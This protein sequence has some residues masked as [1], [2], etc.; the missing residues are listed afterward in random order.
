MTLPVRLTR[1]ANEDLGHASTR[2]EGRR[3]GLG[4]VFL[5]A[6]D[7]TIDSIA[8]WPRAGTSIKGVRA[9]LHA[10]RMGACGAD[11]GIRTRDPHLGKAIT[12]VSSCVVR[13]RLTRS[14]QVTGPAGTAS[15]HPVSRR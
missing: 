1:E 8:P 5:A 13:S 2:Y 12:T 6:V 7:R 3:E 15:Y 9:D 4:I 14:E 11:D 10:R